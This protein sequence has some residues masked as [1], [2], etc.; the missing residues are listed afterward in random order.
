MNVTA[1]TDGKQLTILGPTIV[2]ITQT[3]IKRAIS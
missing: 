2:L 3:K 1:N